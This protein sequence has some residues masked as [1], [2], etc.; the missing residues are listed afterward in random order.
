MCKTPFYAKIPL[1]LPKNPTFITETPFLGGQKGYQKSH[2]ITLHSKI[3]ELWEPKD[4]SI[5]I[6]LKKKNHIIFPLA[7]ICT[8]M[9][10]FYEKGGVEKNLREKV[11]TN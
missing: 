1:F 7:E 5:F 9:P 3:L 11:D 6:Y 8:N 10:L 4:L 2:D